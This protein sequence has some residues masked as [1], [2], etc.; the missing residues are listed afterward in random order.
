MESGWCACYEEQ[1]TISRIVRHLGRAVEQ[2]PYL[3]RFLL[4]CLRIVRD[5]RDESWRVGTVEPEERITE[6][7]CG[8]GGDL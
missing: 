4:S 1:G 7:T 5:S 6:G 8:L 2:R 3:D